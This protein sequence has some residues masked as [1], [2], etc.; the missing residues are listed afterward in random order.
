M[1]GNEGVTNGLNL[2]DEAASEHSNG[3]VLIVTAGMQYALYVEAMGYDVL[4]GS[5]PNRQAV[6]NS[7]VQIL[8]S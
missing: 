8:P 2:A 4:T 6:I 3:I 5:I 7:F 1:D